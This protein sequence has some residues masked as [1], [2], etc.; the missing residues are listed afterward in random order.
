MPITTGTTTP[1][2]LTREEVA[3]IL[4]EAE[5]ITR[6]EASYLKMLRW[7]V[8]LPLLSIW[9]IARI[10]Q[11]DEKTISG[12]LAG[13]KQYGLV[14]HVVFNEPGWPRR[15]QRYY[16]TD[17]GL[18][19]LVA[20]HPTRSACANSPRATPSNGL[21]CWPAWPAPRSISSS[22]TWSVACWLNAQR[23]TS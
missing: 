5:A 15:H 3:T 12:Y 2:V 22:P 13:L 7:L 10:M 14:D 21:T 1:P 23:D 16:I 9:E 4:V 8:W 11:K 18:Y 19:V 17:P 20:R 6:P